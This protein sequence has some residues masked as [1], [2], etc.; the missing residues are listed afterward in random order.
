MPTLFA[1]YCRIACRIVL[2]V[3]SAAVVVTCN[4]LPFEPGMEVSGSLDVKGLLETAQNTPI[5]IDSLVIELRRTSDSAVVFSQTISVDSI[6]VSAD[7][8]TVSVDI[9]VS[10]SERSEEFFLYLAV[11]GDGEIWFVVHDLVTAT[12]GSEPTVTDPIE[13]EYVG[14]GANADDVFISLSDTTVT[15]GDSLLVTGMVNDGDSQVDGALVWFES[16]DSNLVPTPQQLGRNQA[17]IFAPTD[18]TD[19][20]TVTGIAPTADGTISTTGMLHFFAR[21]SQL[22]S[23]SGDDQEIY[24]NTAAAGPIVVQV[25]DAAGDPFTYGYP[26]SFSVASGPTGTTVDPDTAI[27]TDVEGFA[28]ATITAG[29]TE[30]TIQVTATAQ[31]LSGS[32]LTFTATVLENQGPVAGITVI[33]DSAVVTTFGDSVQYT[34][35]CQ[36]SVATPVSCGNLSWMSLAPAVA[37]V[38]TLG[39]AHS[40]GA[41][42]TGIV[43]AAGGV[44]DTAQ[45]VVDGI[46]T[47]TISPTDTVITAIGDS[48]T[49]AVSGEM[50]LGGT[51]AIPNDSVVWQTLTPTVALA[52]SVGKVRFVGSGIAT[53]RATLGTAS[54]DATLRVEQTPSSFA[55]LPNSPVIGVGGVANLTGYTYDRNGYQVPGRSVTWLSRNTA[56]ATVD[57][58]GRVAGVELG[59]TYVVGDDAGLTD[60]AYVDVV[61]APP[62]VLQWGADSISVGRG[63]SLQQ[64]ILLSVPAPV[65]G[66]VVDVVSSD[67]MILKPTTPT[68]T[69]YNGQTS[70]TVTFQ[71]REAGVVT[72][73][74][75]DQAAIFAPDTL[76]VGVLSTIEFRDVTDPT[77]RETSFS[78]NS[79]EAR[80]VLVFLSDP[81]PQGGLAVNV[82]TS[83]DLVAVGNPSLAT[84]PGGQLSVEIDLQGNGVG[85]ATLTPE[86]AGWVG[87]PSTVTTSLAQFS[88]YIYSPY[89][90]R[91][92][93]MQ[94]AYLRV[95]VPNSMDRDLTVHLSTAN[96]NVGRTEVDSVV[97]DEGRTSANFFYGGFQAGLDTI[98]ASRSGWVEGR[99]AMTV[100]TPKVEPYYVYTQTVGGPAINWTVY[101]QDSIGTDHPR[102]DTLT[103]SV[104][105]RDPSV[106]AVDVP[107]AV[108]DSLRSYANGYLGL[109]PVGAGTAHL[110]ASADGHLSDSVLVTVNAPK[111]SISSSRTGT[112]Q[113]STGSVYLPTSAPAPVT[114][115]L[116]SLDPS[117]ATV[118]DSVIFPTGNTGQS[119]EIYGQ[120]PGST[121][122]IATAPGYEPDTVG[123]S[124]TT[125]HL[126]PSGLT[127]SMYVTAGFD[128]FTMRTTDLYGSTHNTLDTVVATLESSDPSVFTV[129]ST[130]VTILPGSYYSATANVLIQNTGQAYMRWSAPGY[131]TDSV[132]ITVNPSPITFYQAYSN[133]R[134]AVDQYAS[135]GVQIP[136]PNG[137][138]DTTYITFTHPG[139]V[140][141]A[142]PDTVKLAPGQTSASFRWAGTAV[143]Y[144]TITASATNFVDGT[145]SMLITRPWLFARD[146]TAGV[147]VNDT[148]YLR[149]YSTDSLA[150]SGAYPNT[151]TSHPVTD[152][153][154]ITVASTDSMVIRVDSTPIW[155]LPAQSSSISNIRLIASGPGTAQI[156]VS[157]ADPWKHD[158]TNVVVVTAPAVAINPASMTLGMGQQYPSYRVTIPNG[159]ADTTYVALEVSDTSVAGFSSDTVQIPPG[160]TYSGYFTVY[161]KNTVAS[162]QITA[163]A[164]GFTQ[165]TSVL[166]VQTP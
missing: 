162:V 153:L 75:T 152:T 30:G 35:A 48:I 166:I 47:L 22:V 15:G 49:L 134:A 89:V 148:F 59:A 51:V 101:T 25:L 3:V 124:V 110:V 154:P 23:V 2:V 156:I 147:V 54:G 61:A 132:S 119:Y 9:R 106:L 37:T 165:G 129:D 117:V 36:D 11:V 31:G 72:V 105:S 118:T 112:R 161:A 86:A 143:G 146:L 109:R 144:D 56:V 74:A 82:A 27:T 92:G 114:V 80:R 113:M 34:A 67:T 24:A 145:T 83:D 69:F 70:Q 159:V 71:G 50:V 102:L 122:I 46:G 77:S 128:A 65:D 29:G 68:V 79:A 73:T 136:S 13:P 62:Q 81:A 43:A 149:V 157:A 115:S 164:P 125:S 39:W 45:F 123:V 41:G 97:I 130:T 98:I 57:A 17:W 66:V 58:T 140:R 20:V 28:Q 127:A 100:T 103:V 5:P 99:Q 7:G 88:F 38:D 85:S 151:Y 33:P 139:T 133:T 84:I 93:A 155:N 131:V 160:Q 19:S 55:V 6:S 121:S 94:R 104:T 163:T 96:S 60:S 14:P 137:L 116:Q 87:L 91:V 76:T 53:V 107:T 135:P 64:A 4:D 138:P 26:V 158:T 111:L 95:S 44:A 108:V 16:S 21:P 8:D 40:L 63:A 52:D 78:I 10:L 90:A 150:G 1:R 18:L 42:V 142:V 32:P 126:G 12:A 120:Q 141:G